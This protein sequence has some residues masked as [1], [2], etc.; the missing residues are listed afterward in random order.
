MAWV[1]GGHLKGN[2][3]LVSLLKFLEIYIL[4]SVLDRQNR[5]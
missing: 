3:F 2:T 1:R 5:L 4:K